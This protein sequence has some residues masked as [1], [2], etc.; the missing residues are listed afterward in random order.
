MKAN[1]ISEEC[2]EKADE[3]F[4]LIWHLREMTTFMWTVVKISVNISSETVKEY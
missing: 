1:S 2:R 4:Q 3:Q